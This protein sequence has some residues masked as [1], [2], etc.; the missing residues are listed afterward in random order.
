MDDILKTMRISGAGM[1]VQGERLRVIAQNLANA[2]SLPQDPG[3]KPYRRQ[4]ITFKNQLD[5]ALGLKTVRVSKIGLD[6]SAFGKRYEPD[7]PAADVDGYVLTPNVNTLIEMTDMREAQRSY[8]ANLSVIKASKAMLN[9]TI[10][11]L[12]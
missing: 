12:R 10:D 2:S 8:E 9:Q 6:R 5:R 4:V 3:G 1:R 11:M 7:H